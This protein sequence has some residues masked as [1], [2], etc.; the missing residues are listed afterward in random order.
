MLDNDAGLDA[1]LD[2]DVN[3]GIGVGLDVGIGLD[4]DVGVGIG[5]GLDAGRPAEKDVAS[6]VNRCQSI[7]CCLRWSRRFA[8]KVVSC[9]RRPRGPAR[10]LEFPWRYGKRDWRAN[11]RS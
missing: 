10:R 2:F 5:V 8:V 4:V 6:C 7:K 9:C 1:G 3:V 11:V